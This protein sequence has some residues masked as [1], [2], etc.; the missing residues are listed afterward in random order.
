MPEPV[1]CRNADLQD[2][3]APRQQL[4]FRQL[5]DAFAYPGRL[6]ELDCSTDALS[7]LLATLADGSVT[8]ADPHTRISS[9]VWRRLGAREAAAEVSQFIVM[10]G[11]R[12]PDFRPMLGS[13]ENP[14]QGATVI[15]LTDGF[16]RGHT[17]HLSGPGIEN[18]SR[19]CVSGVD[20]A[21]WTLRSQWNTAFPLGIDMI[22]ISGKQL[23]AIP[24]TTHI[25]IEGVE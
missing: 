2:W 7:L 25:A 11:G 16:N 12:M 13:L 4:A 21:W 14:E 17:L 6:C 9:D 5:L 20:P 10:P 8:L 22:L 19:L 18:Q 23:A 3:Q 15:L 24:R 1:Q